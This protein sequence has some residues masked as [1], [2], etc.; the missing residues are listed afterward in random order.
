MTASWPSGTVTRAARCRW[1]PPGTAPRS[2]RARATR[3]R[4][5]RRRPRCPRRTGRRRPRAPAGG[6]RGRAGRAGRR[7]GRAARARPAAGAG[8]VTR[9]ITT[10]LTRSPAALAL[11]TSP[12]PAAPIESSAMTGPSTPQMPA[13]RKL[14]AARV[15]DPV[16]TQV[17][18]RNTPHPSR[19]SRSID[20]PAARTGAGSRS[21]LRRTP[22]RPGRPQRPPRSPGHRP[23]RR[24]AGRRARA[25][26]L[27]RVA[28]AAE[29]RIGP[30][31]ERARH[32]LG[33]DPDQRRAAQRLQRP[34]HRRDDRDGDERVV[35]GQQQRRRDGLG[36]PGAEVR[37][38]QDRA[39]REPVGE[40]TAEQLE[41][42]ERNGVGRDHDAEVPGESEASRTANVRATQTIE[43]LSSDTAAPRRTTG[44]AGPRSGCAAA[45]GSAPVVTTADS[46]VRAPTA[47]ARRRHAV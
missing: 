14:I 6:R 35:A 46:A 41:Q 28:G 2:A 19:R 22:R 27:R 38:H 3:S 26:D 8:K 9:Y 4:R 21:R 33:H 24:R 43:L 37:E 29:Q 42:R 12:Q 20:A 31:D 11:S 18:E 32:Q 16:Q 15:T 10:E 39:A 5:R 45:T 17:S 40:G 7:R 25:H 36:E 47:S 30:L 1:R 23:L 44:T 34:V 13:W